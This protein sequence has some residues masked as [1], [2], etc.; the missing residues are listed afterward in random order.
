MSR[1]FSM[2]IYAK[3]NYVGYFYLRDDDDAINEIQDRVAKVRQEMGWSNR[4]FG[5][6]VFMRGLESVEEEILQKPTIQ[7]GHPLYESIMLWREVH[8]IYKRDVRD[9]Q[10]EF[11]CEN[12]GYY[13]FLDWADQQSWLDPVQV[14]QAL[15][16]RRQKLPGMMEATGDQRWL[17]EVLNK[18]GGTLSTKK[19]RKLAEEDRVIDEGSEVDWNRLK[20]AAS[21][22]GLTGPQR[23]VWSLRAAPNL[24]SLGRDPEG[25]DAEAPDQS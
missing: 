14:E 21:R 17:M 12:M 3:R 16:R 8:S 13:E 6:E 18:H 7:P 4:D 2:S 1:T 11:L 5:L 23:G 20:K 9:A 10:L 24:P 25:Q 15:E 22:L 19:I